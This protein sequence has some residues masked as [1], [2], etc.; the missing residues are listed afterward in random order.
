[1]AVAMPA[2]VFRLRPRAWGWYITA[3]ATDPD[4]N[5]SE[6]SS[7]RSRPDRADPDSHRDPYGHANPNSHGDTDSYS[8]G[9]TNGHAHAYPNTPADRDGHT[10]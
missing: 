4:N 9:N 6:F 7:A 3:T 10:G 2:S 5:T 8:D 1:M